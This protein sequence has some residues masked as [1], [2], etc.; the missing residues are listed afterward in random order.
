MKRIYCTGEIVSDDY[1]WLFEWF[2][3]PY[4]APKSI[5][6]ELD[7][8]EELEIWINS[9]G[10]DLIAALDIYAL[11]KDYKG[12]TKAFVSGIS[13][14][15]ASVVM[16]GCDSVEA[17]HAAQI[18][19]HNVWTQQSGDYRDMEKAAEVLKKA[20]ESLYT[21]YAKKTG[22][23]H[24]ELKEILDSET[25]FTSKE[26]LEYGLIDSV[27]DFGELPLV[28]SAKYLDLKARFDKAME[29]KNA[30]IELEKERTK[31]YE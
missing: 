17:S 3:E 29:I 13:A 10:G 27:A 19:V 24:D 1:A 18:M 21:V 2:G 9:P 23:S 26:A 25:W 6:S 16:L 7:K 31:H 11:L 20:N 14:S 15:A 22:K 12:K 30:E 28:A 8:G 4:F 5:R